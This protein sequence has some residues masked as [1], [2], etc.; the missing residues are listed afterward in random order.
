M[1]PETM[2]RLVRRWT[3]LYTSGVPAEER[4]RRREE[5]A[6]DLHDQLEHERAQGVADRRIARALLARTLRGLAADVSWRGHHAGSLGAIVA[7]VLVL[8]SVPAGAMLAGG[9][10]F[11]WGVFDFVAAGALLLGVGLVGRAVLRRTRDV[12]A[13][14]A[15]GVATLTAFALVFGTLAVGPL[16]GPVSTGDLLALGVLTALC[17]GATLLYRRAVAARPVRN[18]RA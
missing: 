13:L 9:G 17:A 16:G 5:I 11:A 2:A 18:R 3:R 6:A 12:V 15:A 7:V 10:G 14:G 8:L 1:S 4:E